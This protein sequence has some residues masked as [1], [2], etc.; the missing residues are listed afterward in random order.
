MFPENPEMDRRNPNGY[1]MTS[2][3]FIR[4]KDT[5]YCV[6]QRLYA[7]GMELGFGGT[8]LSNRNR[9]RHATIG[10]YQK[11]ILTIQSGMYRNKLLQRT[12][13]ERIYS[14]L[15]KYNASTICSQ[16]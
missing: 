14:Q 9:W 8:E 7:M 4:N 6:A 5:D 16:L 2:T 15:E 13:Y 11:S 3:I 1:P 12:T 10:E